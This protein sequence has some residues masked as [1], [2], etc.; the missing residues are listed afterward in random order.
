MDKKV[1]ETVK[2]PFIV[3]IDDAKME[4][5]QSINN[6]MQ[7]HGLPLYLV[8]MILTDIYAQVKEGAKNELAMARA[9]MVDPE[10]V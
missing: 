8:D 9:Q 1:E 5:I 4:I 2:R 6:A 3:E 10:I 7:V